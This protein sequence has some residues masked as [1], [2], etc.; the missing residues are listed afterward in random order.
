M[1]NYCLKECYEAKPDCWIHCKLPKENNSVK[2][3]PPP[4]P[5]LKLNAI[6]LMKKKNA[7]FGFFG[8]ALLG[9][10]EGVLL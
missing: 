10:L 6:R 8:F 2:S 9:V 3:K 4:K 1:N 5:T 7:F